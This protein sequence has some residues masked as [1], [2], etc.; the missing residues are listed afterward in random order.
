[1]KTRNR[2]QFLQ[3]SAAIGAAA[4]LSVLRPERLAAQSA[5]SATRVSGSN[6]R[7]RVGLIG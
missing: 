4:G 6:D 2:R 7:I 3:D 1:M 5:A